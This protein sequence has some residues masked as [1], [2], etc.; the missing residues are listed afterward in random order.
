MSKRVYISGPM[1]GKPNENR[2]LFDH[3]ADR[4]EIAGYTV[5]NPARH[6]DGLEHAEYMAL[7]RVDVKHAD[8]VATLPGWKK[9]KG[10]SQERL[11]AIEHKKEL[12]EALPMV[13]SHRLK[14][15]FVLFIRSMDPVFNLFSLIVMI[16]AIIAMAYFAYQKGRADFHEELLKGRAEIGPM[17]EKTDPEESQ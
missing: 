11:W 2:P 9:S 17:Y 16:G 3:V 14:I 8:I 15:F 12:A 6:P 10:A 13:E 5:L 1:S 4:L 7:A